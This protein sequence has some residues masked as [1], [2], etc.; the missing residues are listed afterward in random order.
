MPA[1][2]RSISVAC[3]LLYRNFHLFSPYWSHFGRLLAT[4][5]GIEPAARPNVVHA[6]VSERVVPR[7]FSTMAAMMNT[8]ALAVTPALNLPA[9][10]SRTSSHR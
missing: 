8:P 9:D 2:R 6:T 10:R 1:Q 5:D 7:R 3:V 4:S